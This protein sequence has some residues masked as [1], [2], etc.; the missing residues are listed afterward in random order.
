M[1]A[2]HYYNSCIQYILHLRVLCGHALCLMV[3]CKLCVVFVY[4]PPPPFRSVV[5]GTQ[6]FCQQSIGSR[7][8]LR[9][10][11][12]PRK[13]AHI[14]SLN[15]QLHCSK[16][17]A[18]QHT[19]THFFRRPPFFLRRESDTAVG[20]A[21]LILYLLFVASNAV[22][23]WL[24]LSLQAPLDAVASR[25]SSAKLNR[26]FCLAGTCECPVETICY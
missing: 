2:R 24:L 9:S 22:S 21:S 6:H 7:F 20:A 19:N 26:T 25:S 12:S 17:L 23:G 15:F 8:A 11:Q 5:D 3:C 1:Y 13:L 14:L 4:V 18:H 10:S 16:A